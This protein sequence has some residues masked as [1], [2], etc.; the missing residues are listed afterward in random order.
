MTH[1]FKRL[2]SAISYEEEQA[3]AERLLDEIYLNLF[4]KHLRQK[5]Q[6]DRLR[7]LIDEALDRKDRLAFLAYTEV[8]REIK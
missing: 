2:L 8:L 3:R 5:Q 6:K 4:M 1:S 7:L